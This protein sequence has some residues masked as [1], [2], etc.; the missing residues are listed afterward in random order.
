[1]IPKTIHYCWFG[2]TPLPELALKCI[3]S[4]K[5]HFPNYEIKEWNEDNIDVNMIPYTKEAYEKKKYAFVSDY[6]RFWILYNYGGIYF[7]TDV[8]VIASMDSIL[9]TGPFMACEQL[10]EQQWSNPYPPINA[11]L[12]LAS[13]SKNPIFARILN[14][15]YDDHFINLDGSLNITTVVKRVSQ[16]LSHY[17]LKNERRI[18]KIEDISI[19]P[20]EYFCPLDNLTGKLILSKNTVSIHHFAGSWLDK[21]VH[22]SILGIIWDKLHL[23]NTDIRHKIHQFFKNK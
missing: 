17:G 7:D 10:N 16:L 8:E 14:S 15:Y 5:K 22:K 9:E 1:M 6:A 13:E 18:Q 4:W 21:E 2:K 20:P 23:P 12:G 19:Y 11:G 3:D